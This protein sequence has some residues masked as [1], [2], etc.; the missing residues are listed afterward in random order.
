[1][2]EDLMR[3][4]PAMITV[5][6]N[7]LVVAS[8]V[9]S[10]EQSAF[11]CVKSIQAYIGYANEMMNELDIKRWGWNMG[12]GTDVSLAPGTLDLGILISVLK[13][14]ISLKRVW[15]IDLILKEYLYL[16][17][18]M[19][20][21][22]FIRLTEV[23]LVMKLRFFVMGPRAA[24][25]VL[26]GDEDKFLHDG[27]LLPNKFE[28]ACQEVHVPL[29]LRTQAGYDH[30]YFFIATFIDDHIHHHAQSLNL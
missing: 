30:S 22:Y 25:H 1:M 26:V 12:I 6:E 20:V 18:F 17:S 29:L 2:K 23:H 4:I 15:W 9:I 3:C 13:R 19:W 24:F 21:L 27:Q 16:C 14:L 8:R 5:H 7:D 10:L 11:I 28:E